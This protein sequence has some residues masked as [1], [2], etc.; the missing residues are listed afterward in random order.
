MLVAERFLGYERPEGHVPGS[1]E[2]LVRSNVV[3][4]FG[5]PAV[6]YDNQGRLFR[7]ELG[8]PTEALPV[9]SIFHKLYNHDN[10]V[11]PSQLHS[12]IATHSY[13]FGKTLHINADKRTGR[14][15][16][17]GDIDSAHVVRGVILQGAAYAAAKKQIKAVSGMERF[18]YA[19]PLPV[20][21]LAIAEGDLATAL[22]TALTLGCAAYIHSTKSSYLKE[23]ATT[24][25]REL[26]GE[27]K[28]D[29][30][31]PAKVAN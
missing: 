23:R 14:F 20:G 9:I 4:R 1:P 15:G 11:H 25:S 5:L 3:E 24:R 12:G 22:L 28:N 10:P 18:I 21:T 27:H 8:F 6:D 26:L 2:I 17:A 16:Q 7:D 19:L 31:F 29:I 30:V 13:R